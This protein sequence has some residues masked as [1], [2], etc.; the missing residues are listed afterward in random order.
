MQV[1]SRQSRTPN[2]G[3]SKPVAL[4]RASDRQHVLLEVAGVDDVTHR[5]IA[6]YP[7]VSPTAIG[8]GTADLAGAAP[9]DLGEMAGALLEAGCAEVVLAHLIVP[10]P[11]QVD[12]R[13]QAAGAPGQ[14]LSLF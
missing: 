5:R 11:E 3:I 8:N 2:S 7:E 10:A 1:G 13:A 12:G 4:Q 14:V 9:N 6:A